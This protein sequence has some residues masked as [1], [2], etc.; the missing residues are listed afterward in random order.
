MAPR[1]DIW[2]I[3][4]SK[5]FDRFKERSPIDANKVL[6]EWSGIRRPT[7]S[8]AF[9]KGL[10]NLIRAN[11]KVPTSV[12]YSGIFAKPGGLWTQSDSEDITAFKVEGGSWVLVKQGGDDWTLIK[13]RCDSLNIPFGIWFHCRTVA[14]L[15][16]L[17][18]ESKLKNHP[19]VGI[20]IEEELQTVLTPTVV[21]NEILASGY[22]GEIV[23][24]VYGWVQ[25]NVKVTDNDLGKYAWLLEMFA[26]DAKELWVP[27]EK[28]E[29]CLLHAKQLG[30]RYPFQLAGN[31][32]MSVQQALE[33]AKIHPSP[34]EPGKASP[35]WYDYTQVPTSVYPANN[36]INWSSGWI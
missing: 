29:G 18:R 15:T 12:G 13:N 20:N 16:E 3:L 6:K 9:A 24:V 26:Q 1:D 19:I 36:V 35:L 5:E 32:D 23:M 14:Q 17:L 27:K 30:I 31:Y 8:S 7:P 21:K 10:V 2:L 4:D 33:I 25:N 28:L 22:T 11:P 34:P